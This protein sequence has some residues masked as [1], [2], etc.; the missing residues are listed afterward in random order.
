MT[1]LE[2]ANYLVYILKEAVNDLTNDK[3]NLLLYFA[4]GHYLQEYGEVLF[5]DVIE[6]WEE[7]PVVP[8]TYLI[9]EA[10]D[11]DLM[12]DCDVDAAKS[13]PSDAKAFLFNLARAYYRFD[14]EE[15][16][17]TACKSGSPWSRIT[18]KSTHEE[19]PVDLIAEYFATQ[20]SIELMTRGTQFGEEDFIGCKDDDSELTETDEWDD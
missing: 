5:D 1:A 2:T 7:G 16:R 6:A 8:E 18:D 17:E 12:T 14:A 20:D 13:L 19:I 9:Y 15:L 4:Q 3:L 10:Y 11:E